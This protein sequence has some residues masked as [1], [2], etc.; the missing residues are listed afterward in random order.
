[1]LSKEYGKA[2]FLFQTRDLIA[3]GAFGQTEFL[4]RRGE[5]EMASDNIED[6]QTVKRSEAHSFV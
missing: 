6:A 2:E 5:A 1:M 4:G 3:D